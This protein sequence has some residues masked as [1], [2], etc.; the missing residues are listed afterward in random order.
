MAL[1]PRLQQRLDLM[2]A[3][4]EVIPHPVAETAMGVA[5]RTH[6]PGR[7]VAKVV[8]VRDASGMDF[9][10]VLPAPRHF[11]RQA[12]RRLTGREGV[13]LEDERVLQERFPDCE[14]GAMPPYGDL[15]GMPTYV[16]P[17]LAEEEEIYF[18]GGNHHELVRMRYEDYERTA[19]PKVWD[20]CMH[21]EPALSPG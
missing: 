12:L 11:D 14:L 17:C 6:V 1:S 3:A 2:K 8:I 18:Q 7:S 5:H 9:M 4:Y 13:R 21:L 19:K 15:Y 16:D 20:C 10:V